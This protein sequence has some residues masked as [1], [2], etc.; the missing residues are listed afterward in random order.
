MN[1]R[2]TVAFAILVG[3]PNV[4]PLV[5]DYILEKV[6]ACEGSAVPE[7]ILDDANRDTFRQYAEMWGLD[8]DIERDLKR[9]MRE[10]LEDE[11]PGTNKT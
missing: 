7:A 2:Q 10:V 1:L 9:P 11:V 4:L 5:P 8:W 6:E 3:G